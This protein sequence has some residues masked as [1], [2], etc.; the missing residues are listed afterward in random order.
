M[1][2]FKYRNLVTNDQDDFVDVATYSPHADD[3][4][5]AISLITDR[6]TLLRIMGSAA[7][8][9]D[10]TAALQRLNDLDDLDD[11]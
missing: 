7:W 3:R 11:D 5:K 9:S 8:A 1:E 6:G 10:E 4:E 2:H